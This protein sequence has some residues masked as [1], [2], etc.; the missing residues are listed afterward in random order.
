VTGGPGDSVYLLYRIL[1][2]AQTTKQMF[3]TFR[4]LFSFAVT[5]P[6]LNDTHLH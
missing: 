4:Y 3:S 1:N 2:S 6:Q 5:D